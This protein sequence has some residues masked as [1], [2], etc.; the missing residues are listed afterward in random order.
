MKLLFRRYSAAR[1]P[2]SP[3]NL[4]LLE[5]NILRLCKSQRL[6]EATHLLNSGEVPPSPVLYASL[7]QTACKH[8][9]LALGLQV[10]CHIIKSGLDADRYVGNSLITLYFKLGCDVSDTRKVFDGLFV[11]D[12]VSWSSMISGYVRVGKFVDGLVLFGDMVSVFG[13]LPSAFSLSVVLKACSETGDRKLGMGFHG[14]VIR[15]GYDCNMVVLSSLIDMYGKQG[16]VDDAW[17]VFRELAYDDKDVVCWTSMISAFTRNDYYEDALRLFCLMPRGGGLWP[18][19]FTFGSILTACGNL[20]RL[21]QGKEIHGMVVVCGF[22]GN[23][24]VESSLIDMYGK[25][26]LTD[27]AQCVFNSMSIKNSV[28]WCA[29]LGAYCQSSKFG[30]VLQLAHEMGMVDLYTF[31]TILRACAGLASVRP[32]K[33]VHCLYVRKGGW[34]DIVVESALVDLYAKCGSIDY[35]YRVFTK[36]SSRNVITWNAMLCGFAHNGRAMEALALFNEMLETRVRPDYITFVGVLFACS[37]GGLVHEGREFFYSMEPMHGVRPGKEHYNCVVDLLGRSGLLEEAEDLI[38][39]SCFRDDPS[40]W[41][42]LLGASTGDENTATAERIAKKMME[43]EPDNHLSY[44][45]LANVYR[46]AG[47]WNDALNLRRV[48]ENQGVKKKPAT[49][50]ISSEALRQRSSW[51]K[52]DLAFQVRFLDAR[53]YH[54]LEYIGNLFTDCCQKWIKYIRTFSMKFLVLLLSP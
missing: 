9:S 19:N 23:V 43:V 50:W 49:S 25:C 4:K 24:V 3:D 46:A 7:L 5:S 16:C 33:E 10:H 20:G 6:P 44:V 21:K 38:K 17:G 39:N 29:L 54:S 22:V 30:I 48:M 47:R 36:I 34:M 2:P 53:N 52:L 18:D 12:D 42:V 31:G 11:K 32:G 35:A 14:T 45:L 51:N 37:H 28:S 41:E 8:P 26:A 40:L 15:I 1:P 27:E 13:V